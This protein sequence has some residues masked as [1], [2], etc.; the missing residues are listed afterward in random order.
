[1][2]DG[3]ELAKALEKNECLVGFKTLPCNFPPTFKVARGEGYQYNEKRTPSYTDRI[4]WKSA[5]GMDNVVPFLYEPCPDFITSDHKPIR[6]GYTLNTN[7]SLPIKS[8]T[9]IANERKLHLLVKDLKCHNLPIMDSEILGGLCDPYILFVSYPK[10]LLWKKGWPLTK[11]KERDLDPKWEEHMFLTLENE[12]YRDNNGNISLD[13]SMLY[14]TIM[15]EDMTSGDDVV[16][17]VALNLKKMFSGIDWQGQSG[18]RKKI[19]TRVS[20]AILRNGTEFGML[21]CTIEAVYLKEKEID[22]FLQE[23]AEVRSKRKISLK[24][25]ITRLLHLNKR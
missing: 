15:D 3:D 25:K 18:P 7:K 4:L 1:L 24:S 22:A 23:S 12:G 16:G 11:V 5:A 13:G 2:N 17:T 21:E 20:E 10:K 6:G 8:S 14:M 9:K 19:V